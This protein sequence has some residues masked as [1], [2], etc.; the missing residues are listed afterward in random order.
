MRTKEDV[1]AGAYHY[2]WFQPTKLGTFPIFC[3]EY[4]GLN[5]SGM[6]GKLRVV[7]QAEFDDHINDRT[8][9]EL[10]PEEIAKQVYVNK[11]CKGCHSLDGTAV[12]GP[13][14]KGLFGTEREF[15]D[16]TKA[17]VDENYIRDSILN[18]NAKVVKGYQPLMPALQLK[19]DEINAIVALLKTLK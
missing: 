4:C 7:T 16:G 8:K 1:I 10:S 6:L 14:W 3:T 9:G 2:M 5:H 19:D 11:G 18:P 13:S 15:A 17:V 12:V